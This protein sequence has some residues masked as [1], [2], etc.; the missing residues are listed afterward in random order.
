VFS[1]SSKNGIDEARA[2]VTGWLQTPLEA[3]GES[4][5]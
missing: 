2:V 4:L 5:G 1:G 3:L